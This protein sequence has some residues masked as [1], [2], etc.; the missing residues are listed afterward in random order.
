MAA[1]AEGLLRALGIRRFVVSDSI[2]FWP[3]SPWPGFETV[4]IAPVLAE[5]LE[6]CLGP[7]G[8]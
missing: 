2:P 5:A 1:G 8:T 6:K 7:K 4:A 3:G